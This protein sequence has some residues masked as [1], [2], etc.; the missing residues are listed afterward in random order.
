MG[1]KL[2]LSHSRGEHTLWVIE[3]RMLRELSD[4]KKQQRENYCGT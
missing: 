4:Y 1:M 3:N 2:G